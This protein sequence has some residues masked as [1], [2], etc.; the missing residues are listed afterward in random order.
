MRKLRWSTDDGEFRVPTNTWREAKRPG[1]FDVYVDGD[2]A[3]YVRRLPPKPWDHLEAFEGEHRWTGCAA[4]S[5]SVSIDGLKRLA[6][7]AGEVVDVW[8][9]WQEV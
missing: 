7:A 8:R 1:E 6:D 4:P 2:F 5:T 3:G 9:E